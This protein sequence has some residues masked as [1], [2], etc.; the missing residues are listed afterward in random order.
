MEE[1]QGPLLVE[2]IEGGHELQIKNEVVMVYG[3]RWRGHDF[4]PQNYYMCV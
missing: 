3:I 2:D 4:R 1:I